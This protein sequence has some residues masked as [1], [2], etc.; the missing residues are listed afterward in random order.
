MIPSEI[1][2]SLHGKVAIV[3]GASRGIG[4]AIAERLAL[5]G[6]RVLLTA[7]D[8][9]RLKDAVASIATRGGLA[10]YRAVDLREA[11]AGAQVVAEAVRL[12]GQVDLLINNA[13]ATKRG[14]FT[15]LTDGDWQD[16]FELK[17]FGTVRL[18]RAAWP[19]L[20]AGRGSVI[21]I[22]GIGGRTPGPHFA[23]GGSVNAALLSF[24]KALADVGVTDGVQVAAINPGFVR[25]DRFQPRLE[26]F[27]REKGL[28]LAAAEIQLV[29]EHGVRRVGEPADVANL[30]A[31]L[32]S[33]AGQ[34]LHGS[35][36]D[37]DGGQTKTI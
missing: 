21:M 7:R 5:Q 12:F 3:T 6:A 13:G 1:P 34:Y 37:L 22:A 16:G 19:L 36:I 27:A 24:T 30:V 14:D 26:A 35:L 28:D 17:F 8:G 20:K 18:T 4:R 2:L 23:I 25:T 33:P 11:S 29:Q 31:Y 10:A 32:V 15:A 9:V